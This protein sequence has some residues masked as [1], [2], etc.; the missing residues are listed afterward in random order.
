MAS[1]RLT[2]PQK[3][4]L[5]A[6]YGQGESSL[7]LAQAFGVSA[8]TVSRVVR[9]ALP[10]ELYESLKQQQ[11][12]KTATYEAEKGKTKRVVLLFSGG[13]DTSVMV[14]WIK[15][16]YGAEVITLTVDL[17]Q[18]GTDL[19][20]LFELPSRDKTGRKRGS[21]PRILHPVP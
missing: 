11:T 9:A 19:Q 17:G 21:R 5:V 7:A 10:P 16:E 13:L 4:E 14:K 3:E 8:N 18:P 20:G 2:E 15:E 12:V 1:S 6:R